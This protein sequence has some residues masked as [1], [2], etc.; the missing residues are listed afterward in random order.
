MQRIAGVSFKQNR[1]IS[2]HGNNVVVRQFLP[3]AEYM[4][5]INDIMNDCRG[6]NDIFAPE[7][8]D[9][10]IK[11]N[12]ITYYAF[13]NLPE[14]PNML[15]EI[16]YGTDLYDTICKYA[17]KSQVDSVYKYISMIMGAMNQ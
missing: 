17:N 6:G 5:M 10:A 1:T 13:V 4:Q 16:V 12:V 15:F 2:W 11:T 9:F 8:L 7:L 14:D 3:L